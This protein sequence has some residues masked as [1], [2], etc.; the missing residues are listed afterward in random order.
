MVQIHSPR[1]FLLE[2]TTYSIRKNRRHPG[3]GLVSYG[4]KCQV[5][6][7]DR[8]DLRVVKLAGIWNVR[9]AVF[10]YL[11]RARIFP[12]SAGDSVAGS[13]LMK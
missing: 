13:H 11:D 12:S 3:C 5:L 7:T 8:F 4:E 6:A 9:F 10:T 1:P 2:P